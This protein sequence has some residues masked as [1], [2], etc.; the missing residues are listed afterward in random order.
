MESLEEA[1]GCA[2]C[3]ISVMRDH[4]GENVAE[5]LR[6]KRVDIAQVGRTF[7]FV[8]SPKARPSGVQEMCE[9][10]PTYVMFVE[11]AT[12]RGAKDKK[13]KEQDTAREYSEDGKNWHPLP[14]GLGPVTG[15]LDAGAS[16]FVF[17]VLTPSGNG[18]LDLWNYADCDDPE[19]PVRFRQGCWA[20]RA[21]QRDMRLHPETMKSRCRPVV[22]VARLVE[23]YCVRLR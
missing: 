7:W 20:V 5:I 23:P 1:M 19:T 17:D 3:I 16:A 12:R 21:V 6:R 9:T 4:A 22:A 8:R 10:G 2:R 11:P 15:K 14:H 18:I 13:E